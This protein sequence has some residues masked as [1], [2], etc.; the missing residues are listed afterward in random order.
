MEDLKPQQYTRIS[1]KSRN[2]VKESSGMKRT[3]PREQN[4]NQRKRKN[5][6]K[7]YTIKDQK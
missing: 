6:S 2:K 5:A 7:N 1:L 4:G 3:N